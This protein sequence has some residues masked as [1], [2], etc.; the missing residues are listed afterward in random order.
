MTMT[1]EQPPPRTREPFFG[2][3]PLSVVLLGGAIG[4]VSAAALL[5]PPAISN[6]IFW[7]CAVKV[8]PGPF[9][10]EQP[11]GPWAPYGLHVFAHGGWAHLLL[12]LAGLAA[13]G[14]ACA[15]R[16]RAPLAFLGF[17]ALCGVAGAL[18]EAALPRDAPTTM[19]GASSG[20]FGLIAGATYVRASRGGR[21]AP[22]A[23][24]A[25]LMGLAP[26]VV[27]NLVTAG[28]GGGAFGGNIAWAA[29][30]GGLAAGALTFPLFD[31]LARKAPR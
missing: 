29:H 17:F 21:L 30:L 28:A 25:M 6:L 11:L 15:R 1:D 24:R 26:W 5:A 31:R 8:G 22:L 2:D 10:A 13:F 27:I 4:F 23:S 14:A 7:T 20:V 19:L 12:N 9:G 3:V 16:L 18:T